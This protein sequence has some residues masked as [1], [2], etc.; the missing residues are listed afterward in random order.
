MAKP[1]DPAMGGSARAEHAAACT[2]LD[3]PGPRSAPELWR[4]RKH[5]V[6]ALEFTTAL[7]L[8]VD[9]KLRAQGVSAE[10]LAQPGEVELQAVLAAAR[11]LA[12]G[13]KRGPDDFEPLRLRLALALRSYDSVFAFQPLEDA[14]EGQPAA[15]EVPPDHAYQPYD[16]TRFDAVVATA[17]A[18]NFGR[19]LL[20]LTHDFLHMLLHPCHHDPPHLQSFV[21]ADMRGDVERCLLAYGEYQARLTKELEALRAQGE[22]L[23]AENEAL[24][25]QAAPVDADEV[26]RQALA[27]RHP[28]LAAIGDALA[29]GRTAPVSSPAEDEL[30]PCYDDQEHDWQP[31]I[32]AGRP[33]AKQRACQRCDLHLVEPGP[34]D[35]EG[36]P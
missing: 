35:A 31:V 17:D 33:S 34:A 12:E 16:W 27:Q 26:E 36:T 5:L 3:R 10:D 20:R 2:I 6:F 7:R 30:P 13:M 22:A 19:C 21:P 32:V 14:P 11:E 29:Q 23:R 4:A 1:K 8:D 28:M 18:D 9:Q 24:R 15:Q 25:A